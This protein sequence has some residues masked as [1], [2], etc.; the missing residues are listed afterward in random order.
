[1]PGGSLWTVRPVRTG[2]AASDAEAQVTL[3]DDLAQALDNL[4]LRQSEYDQAGQEILSLRRQLFADWYKYMMCAY[5]PDDARDDYPEIDLVRYFIEQRDLLPLQERLDATGSL[6]GD[7]AAAIGAVLSGL[8]TLNAGVA[9]QAGVTYSLRPAPAPRFW[10][11]REPVVL[12]TGATVQP[13]D[14]HGRD[15]LLICQLLT[16]AGNVA[17]LLPG[18]VDTLTNAITLIG[19]STGIDVWTGQPW[20]PIL[21]EWEVEVLPLARGSNHDPS[22]DSYATGF[23]TDAFSL[24]LDQPDLALLPD[25]GALQQRACI[26]SGTSFLTPHAPQLMVQRLQDFP[27]ASSDTDLLAAQAKLAASTFHCL[28]QSLG[29]FNEALLM[30]RQTLQL[31]IADPLG[32]AGDQPFT[33]AV[34]AA[35]DSSAATSA[36]EPLWDF[37]PI[38]NGAM[39]L[40]QLRL[41]DTFGQVKDLD[42]SQVLTTEALKMPGDSTLVALPP[43]LVQPARLNF[44]WL[45]A[46]SDEQEMNDQPA[47]T[48]VCGWLLP[49]NLDGSL[50][51]YDNQG[52]AQGILDQ[53]DAWR[54]L[55]DREAVPIESIANPHLQRLVR[56]LLDQTSDFREAFLSAIDSSLANI[57]PEN[58]AQ[59]QDLALLLGR[60]VA[61]VR[62][63]LGLEVQGLPAVHQAWN[64][65]RQDLE[66]GGRDDDRFTGVQLPIRLGEYRQLNDGLVGYWQEAQDGSYAGQIFYSP[67][68][69]PVGHP[70]I[71]THGDDPAPILQTLAAPPLLLSLLVDPRGA[72]HATSGIL[73]ALAITLPPDQ[74]AAAL[75]AIEIAFLTTPILTATGSLNLPLPVEAGYGWSW[76]PGEV[77]TFGKARP[78][79]S[80]AAQEIREGWLKLTPQD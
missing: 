25:R 52:K 26:Y 73:P 30:R 39:R 75:K 7:V 10:L 11:P 14:R 79:A 58:F 40:L 34:S 51:I 17:D 3:P 20:N 77:T 60:P 18:Q 59:H 36:P 31:P 50:M 70:R 19:T 49:N 42:C 23:I 28:S 2:T 37:N 68:S 61:L 29:G 71:K 13:N 5:P 56:Y 47:T 44:R 15:G 38:R 24:P 62:A 63:R 76:L 72:V 33:Q 55:A 53:E 78:E 67:Q 45:A 4:N 12:L 1:V 65:F 74:Y 22:T 69:D 16:G 57:D 9:T 46:A 21:L 64:A 32:F 35:V 41:V 66:R 8:E 43:R 6:A 80:F 27:G 48:P 54:G